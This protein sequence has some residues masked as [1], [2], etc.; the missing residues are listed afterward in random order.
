MIMDR[1]AA[2]A[3]RVPPTAPSESDISN[4]ITDESMGQH[5]FLFFGL[6]VQRIGRWLS[7][8]LALGA[9][10]TSAATVEVSEVPGVEGG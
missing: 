6:G 8:G 1:E 3:G 7:F 10:R 2:A 4:L 5:F 9:T